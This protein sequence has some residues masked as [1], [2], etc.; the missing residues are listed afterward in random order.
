[1]D[2]LNQHECMATMTTL[3]KH[4]QRNQIL[5]KGEEVFLLLILCCFKTIHWYHIKNEYLILKT[6]SNSMSNKHDFVVLVLLCHYCLIKIWS[7]FMLLLKVILRVSFQ[8]SVPRNLPPWMKFLHD[9]LGNSSVS[10][11]IRLFLAK[12]VINTEEVSNLLFL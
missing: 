7:Y 10:L 6:K 4:M 2:E 12:L 5:P 9:K 1:M 3:I 8:G 11:N